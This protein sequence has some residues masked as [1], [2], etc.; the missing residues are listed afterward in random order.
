[1]Q[2]VILAAGRGVRMGELT[3]DK[4]KPLLEIAGRPI[5]EYTLE[6]LPE[7][8]LEVVL[9]I[10]YKGEMIKKHFGESWG[11][12]KISYVEQKQMDGTGGA[13]TAARDLLKDKFLVLMADD[14]YHRS[15]LAKLLSYDLALLVREIEQNTRFGV[16]EKDEKENLKSIIEFKDLQGKQ[17]NE[18]LVN[19]GAYMLNKEFFEYPL[20]KISEKEYGL[21]QTLAQMADK[22]KIKVIKAE[23]WHPNGQQEDLIKGEE[24][25]KKHFNI[26]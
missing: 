7:E 17:I 12:K 11:G 19:M 9:V 26:D 4:P 15:D 13:I 1:M 16:V 14:L 10:G 8:I 24:V 25:V 21:P 6:N 20:V 2:A 3:N 23:C 22:Y 18:H 5:L